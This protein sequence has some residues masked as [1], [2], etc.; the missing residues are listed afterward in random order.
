MVC[1]GIY[2]LKL[3]DRPV[4]LCAILE[5]RLA[6]RG[7]DMSRYKLKRYAERGFE[8]QRATV[9]PRVLLVGEAAG[10]DGLSGEGIAT[11][12]EYAAIAGPYLAEKVALNDFLFRDFPARV[13]KSKLGVDLRLR[14]RLLT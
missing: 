1:R 14:H 8:P 3:D 11:S 2:H 6:A 9:T 12:V 4:D 5:R 13:S 7:L 10:I